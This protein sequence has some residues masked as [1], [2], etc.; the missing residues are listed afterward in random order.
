M[1]QAAARLPWFH[2]CTLIDKFKTREERDWHIAKA[3]EHNWSRNVLVLVQ[4]ISRF[5]LALGAGFAFVG[6]QV[7]RPRAAPCACTA[8]SMRNWCSITCGSMGRFGGQT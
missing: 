7:L 6:K 2:L 4:H 5:L 8:C 3:V 1:Q